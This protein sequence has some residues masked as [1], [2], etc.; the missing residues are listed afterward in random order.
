MSATIRIVADSTADIP[1]ELREELGIVMV[2]LKVHFGQDVY[3][4]AV[5]ITTDEF[6][7][8]LEASSQL[9]T[10]SQPSPNDFIEVYNGILEE[11]PDAQILSFHL[12][13]EMSGTYQSAVLAESLIEREADITVIDSKSASFGFGI[14]VVEA[15]RMARAGKSK[16]EILERVAWLRD[17]M[18]LYFLVDTLEYLQKGGRIGKASALI[19]SILNIKPILT[20]D[21]EGF[22]AS[23]DKV[24][25]QRKAM[26][27]I[28]DLLREDFKDEPVGVMMAYSKHQ[29]AATELYELARSHFN[30]QQVDYTTIG[31]VIGTHVGPG[32]AAIFMFR[33]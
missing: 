19:G 31:S 12:S 4:D 1:Q 9:P 24:R 6:Y 16:E 30:V 20:V 14:R 23:V 25:G 3:L 27:R 28:V 17:N 2:P 5:T 15:A 33:V 18:R 22:V 13:S 32:T 11:T 7:A 29:G 21:K 26:Q 10:T 8:K